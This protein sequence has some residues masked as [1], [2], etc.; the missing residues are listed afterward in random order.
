M[1]S[2]EDQRCIRWGHHVRRITCSN[3]TCPSRRPDLWGQSLL[4]LKATGALP[5]SPKP[6]EADDDPEALHAGPDI[7]DVRP[8][9]PARSGAEPLEPD[10]AD[11][12]CI[13]WGHHVRQVRHC[14]NPHCPALRPDLWGPM[15]AMLKAKEGR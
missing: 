3:P 6:D 9:Q 13:R 10:D 1:H 5:R 12:R 14:T 11:A 2:K 7:L 8:E 4:V 15:I